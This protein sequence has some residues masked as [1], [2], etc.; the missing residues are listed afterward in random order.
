MSPSKTDGSTVL[1]RS[2][3]ALQDEFLRSAVKFTADRLRKK[4]QATTAD[5]GRWEEWRERGR[6]IRAHTIAHLDYYLK[7]FANRVRAAGGHVYFAADATEAAAEIVRIA[8]DKQART[9]VKSKSMVTEEIHLNHHLQ[10][11]GVEVVE[12]DLGEYIIQLA[13]EAP[14]HIIIPAIHKTREQ[15]RALFTQAGGKDLTTDTKVLAGFARQTLRQ[16]FLTAD[17]GITGCNFG[18]AES[19]TIVL[20]TNEGNADMVTN[21]PKTHIVV[22]GIERV[23]PTFADL[24]VIANLLPR[25]ATGQKLTTY[26]SMITGPRRAGESDGAE[27]LHVI[28]VDNGR[29]QQ[30]GDPEFQSVLHCIRCGACLNVCPV[31]RQIGGHAYGSVYPGPIGA[32][33]TPLLNQGPEYADLPYASSLCGACSEACPVKIPLHD[34]LVFLRQRNVRQKRTKLLERVAFRGYR[35]AFARAGRYKAAVKLGRIAQKPLVRD[36]HIESTMGPLA[37]W[38]NSRFAPALATQSFRERWNSLSKELAKPSESAKPEGWN[39]E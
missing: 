30:L 22:M 37:G 3:Q 2:R 6:Q 21:L 17:I 13:G 38:T 18:I 20:F 14:S 33:L 39:H 19:G 11:A 35:M 8:V 16:K 32:V 31:Y 26:M 5:F 36:G 4:K 9:V 28:L 29:S 34:M 23:L 1:S 12:T 10:Q 24:E 25:S 7:Q 27:E 15:I